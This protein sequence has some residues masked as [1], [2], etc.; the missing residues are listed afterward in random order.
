MSPKRAGIVTV[1]VAAVLGP[2]V[3]PTAA[4]A[5]GPP[6]A[7]PGDGTTAETAGASCWGIKQRFS[8]SATGVYWLRTKTLVAPEKF[9]CDMT[10]DGGG[11]AL[12]GVGR[13]GWT[14]SPAAQGNVARLQTDPN[15]QASQAPVHLS[16]DK[17]NG[18]LDGGAASQ[19]PDGI[20]LRRSANA[21]GTSWQ[22]VRW[23][24]ANAEPWSWH[25][26][27]GK[28]LAKMTVNG[29][30]YS[31]AGT[32]RDTKGNDAV[33]KMFNAGTGVD[34]LNRVFTHRNWKVTARGNRAG[35]AM[36]AIKSSTSG[37]WY[38]PDGTNPI[39]LTQVWVRPRIMDSVAAPL[40]SG[41]S[42]PR[43]VPWVPSDVAQEL[44]WGVGG[45]P[46]WTGRISA[47]DP[48]LAYVMAMQE[49]GGRM[50]V[51]GSFTKVVNNA[52]GS[53]NHKFLTAFDVNTGAWISSCK[54]ILD[55]RVWDME[56]SRDGQLIIAGDFTKVNGDT[57]AAGLAKLN[58][59]TCTVDPSFR[60]R[61]NRSGGRGMVRGISLL[62]DRLFI[63]GAFN[64]VTPN[65][66]PT[67]GVSNAAEVNAMTGQLGTWRP[68]VNGLV[69][70][71]DA[72]E[73]G[74]R[75]Y[76][77]GWFTTINGIAGEPYATR[78]SDG[79]PLTNFRWLRSAQTAG[80]TY[81]QTV[82]EFGDQVFVGGREHTLSAY[83]RNTA[84]RTEAHVSIPG[85]DFQAAEAAFG[86]LFGACHCGGDTGVNLSGR[87][88]WY[89]NIADMTWGAT[90]SDRIQQVGLYDAATGAYLDWWLPSIASA[91]GDGP[92][93]I[94][95]DHNECV[96]QG[97]DTK[98]DA[99]SGNAAKDFAGGFTKYCSAVDRSVP[100]APAQHAASLRPDGT[101][102]VTWGQASDPSNDVRYLV[103]RDGNAVGFSWGTSYVDTNVPVG[104]HQYAVAAIDGT[105]NIGPS[106]KPTNFSVAAPIVETELMPTGAA[107]RFTVDPALAPENWQA[108]AFADAGWAEGPAKLGFGRSDVASVIYTAGG[109]NY[110]TAG[111]FRAKVN[112]PNP[113][114]YS[115]LRVE[116]VRDDGAAVSIN[117]VEAFRDNLPDGPLAPT[118]G[119]VNVVEGAAERT[120]VV[121]T[122]P[123]SALQPGVNTIAVEVHN[124]NKWSGDMGMS[125]RIVGLS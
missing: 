106:T 62:G 117:G 4:Q 81:S 30:V 34:G 49:A 27:A 97:G 48:A 72:S 92:W 100:T 85:G 39:P 32:T 115:E 96:W 61:V 22:E 60:V 70:D 43:Q 88:R 110:P 31:R 51:G 69:M 80:G 103:L 74:D 124:A 66:R 2:V 94:T 58:P 68:V 90:R 79:A 111:Y 53:V 24:L 101:V 13:E 25:F 54:P 55:G 59:N 37:N 15:G 118:T 44:A 87:T 86:Y 98:R 14:W 121:Y 93:V 57:A 56:V 41:G 19:L 40:P 42:A 29:T 123:A 63:G 6:A 64:Q 50:F 120:P 102:G 77:A 11:W 104:N 28:P 83:N 23:N 1:M 20:R 3:V 116:L 36:G 108:P 33:T 10:T 73:R 45:P 8:Q 125:M 26:S 107:W 119:A 105:G 16:A 71:I 113:S 47:A 78:I 75:V 52:G 46:D 9:T 18:L 89:G 38:A 21:A 99:Y 67:T 7:R 112:V 91:T 65:G 82:K 5:A 76:L 114:K 35:F 122:V 109:P 12:I 17:I 95:K 84:A